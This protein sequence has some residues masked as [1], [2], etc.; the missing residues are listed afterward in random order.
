MKIGIIECGPV[1]AALRERYDSYPAMFA[2]QLQPLLPAAT[3]TTLSVVNGEA[4]P[5]PSAQDAYLLTGSRHGVYDDLPWI[6]PLKS[7]IRAAALEQRR[8]MVGICFGHQIIAEALGGKVEK[9]SIGFRIGVERYDTARG[10]LAMP[11]FHQDQIVVQ[12]PDSEIVA[13]SAACAYAGLRYTAAPVLS[14]QFHPEFSRDYLA[15]LIAVMGRQ[16]AQPG[17]P[18]VSGETDAAGL[19]WVA[20]F[21][22]EAH[23]R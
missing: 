8:P 4:L 11:A 7:F 14:L 18:D 3:F 10:A 15:D 22:A 23:A 12:P 16:E 19:R 2:A 20:A 9:A 5:D 21:L 6:A 1:P 17:L 13:K